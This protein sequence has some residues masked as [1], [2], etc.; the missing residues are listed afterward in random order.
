MGVPLSVISLVTAVVARSHVDTVVSFLTD[1]PEGRIPPRGV[2]ERL[3]G[4]GREGACR[5][6][7][8]VKPFMKDEQ[9]LAYFDG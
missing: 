7:G 9:I 8:E 5:A 2:R 3:E 4:R 6:T 1:C